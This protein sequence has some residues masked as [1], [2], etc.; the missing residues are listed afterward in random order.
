MHG[1][2]YYLLLAPPALLDPLLH[3]NTSSE[4]QMYPTRVEL[5]SI[6]ISCMTDDSCPT[7]GHELKS[8]QKDQTEVMS[9]CNVQTITVPQMIFR[10][11]FP[12]LQSFYS[13]SA[14]LYI[15][16]I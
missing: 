15:V 5:D 12:F 13:T 16:G 7:D 6:I 2:F 11:W 9:V 8:I 14:N 10:S 3:Y 1:A 4:T